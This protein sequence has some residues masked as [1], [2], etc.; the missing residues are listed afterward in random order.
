VREVR[1]RA[2]HRVQ[3]LLIEALPPVHVRLGRREPLGRLAQVILVH[4]AQGD[5]VLAPQ[6]AEKG[7]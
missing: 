1:R 3:A 6:P 5:D 7:G 4:V 2:D